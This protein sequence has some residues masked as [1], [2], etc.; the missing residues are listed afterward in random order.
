MSGA[1]SIAECERPAFC[2]SWC[3]RHYERWKRHGDPLRYI[4]A[5]ERRTQ[6][7]ADRFWAKVDKTDDCWLWTASTNNGYGSIS[8][9]ARKRVQAHR[10]AYELLVGPI[11]DGLELDHLCR[12]RHCVNP[13][14]LEPVTARENQLRSLSVSGINAAK[15]HCI[16]GHEYTPENTYI[17]PCDGGRDC[18]ACR[19]RR[20]RDRRA[21]A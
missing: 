3:R 7:P 21:A 4:P 20:D 16:W 1:C 15:T 10:F 19:S 12:V 8:L 11:P 5:S 14:H 13:A 9:G 2:R 17:R 18:R 6:S